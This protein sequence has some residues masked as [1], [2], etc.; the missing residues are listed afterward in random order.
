[1]AAAEP[2]PL[3]RPR[4]ELIAVS[5]NW[6]AVPSEDEA[7]QRDNMRKAGIPPPPS[8]C[9][10]SL[11]ERA[12]VRQLVDIDEAGRCA[13]IDVVRL[14]A[15]ILPD[16]RQVAFKPA[17]TFQCEMAAALTDWI[18]DEIAPITA[19]HLGS[20]LRTVEGFDSFSCRGR[21]RIPGAKL[22]EHGKANA[23][24]LRSL[25]LA[26]GT[27]AQP[28]DA[29]IP[30]DFRD[31]LR[32]GACGRFRTVLGP[33][34]DS[35]HENHIHLDLAARRGDYKLCQWEVLQPT[36]ADAPFAHL[37]GNGRHAP[38]T[39]S[40]SGPSAGANTAETAPAKIFPGN[41]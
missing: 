10:L 28:T 19:A 3:P 30:K 23:F 16:G 34:A 2:V 20:P 17:G 35:Y 39:A 14:E 1:M 22:S 11:R 6:D 33:D 32:I 40:R 18:R 37:F 8:A 29:E 27:V 4:P 12:V 38:L 5:S 26:D 25:K 7:D 21:N 41:L 13:V 9:F 31:G 36:L 15:V 24:D